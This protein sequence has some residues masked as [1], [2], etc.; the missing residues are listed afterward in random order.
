MMRRETMRSKTTTTT[1]LVGLGGLFL[2]AVAPSAPAAR[3][4]SNASLEGSYGLHATGTVLGVG[5]FAAVG[6]FS[7]DGAGNLAGTLTSRVNGNTFSRENLTGVYS[8]TP[9]CMVTDTWNFD[10]GETSQHESVIVDRGRGYVILNTSPGAPNVIS[11]A[12]Q[13]QFPGHSERD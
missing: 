12:A 1:L 4:C 5:P 3:S 6:V 7:F 13:K 10:S 11:G 9:D 2:V 8:V